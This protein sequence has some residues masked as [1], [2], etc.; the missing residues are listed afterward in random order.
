MCEVP[1]ALTGAD[2]PKVNNLQKPIVLNG[3]NCQSTEAR[4]DNC[5]HEEVVEYCSHMNDA[6]AFCKGWRTSS[7]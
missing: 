5:E 1:R 2:V 4:L 6:G 3:L 7:L